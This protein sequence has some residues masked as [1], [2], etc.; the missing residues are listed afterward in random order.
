MLI[1][2]RL[3]TTDMC[4]NITQSYHPEKTAG[5]IPV[6]LFTVFSMQICS[7]TKNVSILKTF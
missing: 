7:T 4:E 1:P 5:N 6:G 2:E 3:K